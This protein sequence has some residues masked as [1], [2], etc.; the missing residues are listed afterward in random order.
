MAFNIKNVNSKTNDANRVA[1]NTSTISNETDDMKQYAII[2]NDTNKLDEEQ[3]KAIKEIYNNKTIT[4]DIINKLENINTQKKEL[5]TK[6]ENIDNLPSYFRQQEMS[7]LYKK[8]TELDYEFLNALKSKKLDN[9]T[10]NKIAQ[11]TNES[12]KLSSDINEILN[13]V[14]EDGNNDIKNMINESI[15]R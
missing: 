11:I 12:M 1:N 8:R 2:I 9:E 13:K 10:R 7:A 15:K 5:Y 4:T 14:Y 3:L 6:Y